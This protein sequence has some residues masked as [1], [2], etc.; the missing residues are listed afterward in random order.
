MYRRIAQRLRGFTLIELLV[1]IAIIAVL[2]GLLLPAVQKVREAAARAQCTNNLKQ[3]SLA[4]HNCNDTYSEL[5]P[6]YGSPVA[7]GPFKGQS[8]VALFWLLPFIEQDALFKSANGNSYS[9]P[10]NVHTKPVKAF[11][12][13]SDPNYGTG[14]LDPGNPWALG[15]YSCNFQAFGQAGTT[16]WEGANKIGSSFTDGTSNTILFAERYARCAD[17]ATL[18]AHGGWDPP[19]MAMFAYSNFNKF[20][21][22]PNP[23]ASAC[24]KTV[25]HTA[26]SGTMQVGL[27]DG[28]VRG[29][30]AG[31]TQP[32][33][34]AV[35]TPKSGDLP[36][37]DW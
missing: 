31:V 14:L 24:D 4:C 7:A 16:S 11:V 8:G 28:S 36:G 22:Q 9:A 3:L 21:V 26:H 15:C 2:I 29:V 30:S 27:A 1:V 37:S 35:C 5:P 20:Q 13:P 32:T 17:R 19:W 23:Y 33:W 10:G 34:Q 6:M 25:A 18:W 12:C